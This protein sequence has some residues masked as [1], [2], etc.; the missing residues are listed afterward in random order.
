MNWH[1]VAILWTVI[2]GMVTF[3]FGAALDED[4]IWVFGGL[5]VV[6]LTLLTLLV[7]GGI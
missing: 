7:G 1:N 5:L 2:I 4:S 3:A 6:F